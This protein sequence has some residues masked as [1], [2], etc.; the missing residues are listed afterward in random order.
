MNSFFFWMDLIAIFSLVPD[1]FALWKVQVRI[2]FIVKVS[3]WAGLAP[4]EVEF[5]FPGSLTS[6]F[7]VDLS[8][9]WKVNHLWVRGIQGGLVFKAH[10]WLYHSTLGLRVIE[11]RRKRRGRREASTYEMST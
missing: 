1:L 3:W 8:A 4:W 11:R 5:R 7:L 2:H 9:L 10:R 6:T